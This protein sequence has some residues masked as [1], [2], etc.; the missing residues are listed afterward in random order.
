[1]HSQNAEALLNF[2][3]RKSQRIPAG[4]K[5]LD[6]AL[7]SETSLSGDL[8]EGK[9]TPRVIIMEPTKEL[10]EQVFEVR[11]SWR[12]ACVLCQSSPCVWLVE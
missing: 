1:M 12:N 3:Q 7:V 2:G 4:F 10:A 11:Y 6:D 5:W 8:C 9:R